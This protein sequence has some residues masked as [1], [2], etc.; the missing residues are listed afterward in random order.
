VV[1]DSVDPRL[2]FRFSGLRTVRRRR[3]DQKD[4][5][6]IL[7]GVQNVKRRENK[8]AITP[9]GQERLR[10]TDLPNRDPLFH[11][12]PKPQRRPLPVSQGGDTRGYKEI[13]RAPKLVVWV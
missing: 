13:I 4:L 11:S 12:W 7:V 6:L 10:E 9:I 8:I 5:Y 1:Y 3:G 2:C